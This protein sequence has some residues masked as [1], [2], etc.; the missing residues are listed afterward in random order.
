MGNVKMAKK[1]LLTLPLLLILIVGLKLYRTSQ[2]YQSDSPTLST[3]T[4]PHF[5]TP[6]PTIEYPNRSLKPE[7]LDNGLEVNSI[8]RYYDPTQESAT[9]N[10]FYTLIATG[11]V[12]PARSVNAKM[13]QLNNFNYPFEKTADFLKAAD[14][15]FINLES[16]LVPNCQ[17]TQEG[18]S[19][20]GDP[21]AVEGLVYAGVNVASLANNH[22]GNRGISGIESTVSILKQNNIA[23]TGSGEAAIVNVRDK[24]FGFLGYNDIGSQEA[25]IA[26]ADNEQ[27]QKEIADLKN[28][29]DFVIV[30]FHWGVEYVSTPTAR[31]I[32]LVHLAIDSGADLI[33]G[34]HPHWVQGVEQY[35]GKFIAYSHGNFVFD[36]MW[37]QETREGVIGKYVFDKEGLAD[38]KFYPVIIENYAQP[39]FATQEEA[40]EILD[41]MKESTLK[42]QNPQNSR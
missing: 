15:V 33:I 13:V 20:C 22:A 23:I 32:E 40:L 5:K 42:L 30:A 41:R 31:Q 3:T 2:S 1:W 8:F 27:V 21:K 29:V 18:M 14:L 37:S 16:P 19:F 6:V 4:P 34:N 9:D 7:G 36:Q 38:V 12:I 17:V 24:K 28:K 11:D 25:G 39:R 10:Q 35:K 26:W